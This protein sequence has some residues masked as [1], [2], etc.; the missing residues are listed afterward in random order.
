MKPRFH[1]RHMWNSMTRWGTRGGGS[2]SSRPFPP[3]LWLWSLCRDRKNSGFATR[4]EGRGILSGTPSPCPEPHF[5]RGLRFASIPPPSRRLKSDVAWLSHMLVTACQEASK[6]YQ[7]NSKNPASTIPN[8]LHLSLCLK[9][10]P[11]HKSLGDEPCLNL[12]N[13]L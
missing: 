11:W 7:A 6:S 1:W 4:G 13:N 12:Y 2:G 8:F 3:P 5:I 10:R 9:Q